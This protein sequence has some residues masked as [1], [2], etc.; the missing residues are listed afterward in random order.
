VPNSY[1]VGV[2]ATYAY[3]DLGRRS[4]L[5]RGDGSVLSYGY[6][7]VS[8]LT[9]LGDNLAGTAYD[10]TL[11]FGYNPASQ[12]ASNTR[13][14][15]AYAWT[16]HYNLNRGYVA[17]GLNQYSATGSITPTYDSKGNLTSAG[18][19]TY[20]YTSENLL[21]SLTNSAP[22]AIQAWSTYSYD[23]LMRLAVIDSSNNSF[24]ASLAYDGQDFIL[25][26]LS[27]GR[28]RRYVR[29]P[30][31]DEPLV[32]YL[33]TPAGTSRL[34]YQ[35]DERG[36]IVR[37]S[38]DAGTPGQIGKYDEYGIGG[39]GRIRYAGQYWLGDGNLIYSRA[40]IYDARLGRFLQPDPIGYGDGMNMYA[41]VGG[42][43][44]NRTDPSGLG[45]ATVKIGGSSTGEGMEAEITRA[46]YEELCWGEG[47]GWGP[48]RY[49]DGI[50]GGGGS[51]QS[52]LKCKL[53][54]G[55]IDVSFD[56]TTLNIRAN[57]TL[58]GPGADASSAYIAG[59]GTA[60]TQN[61]GHINSIANISA[62]PDGVIAEISSG[63]IPPGG[64]RS[65]LGGNHM[66]LGNLGAMSARQIAYATQHVAPH[67]F[68][69]SLKIDNM[70]PVGK[71]KGAIMANSANNVS[72]TDLEA[73]VE[74]CRG[75][76]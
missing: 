10:Q 72:A 63:I 2:L 25:E 8:R 21:T 33:V 19:K 16:G 34:W 23:P 31:I 73:V 11:G 13:S 27:G 45:C 66:W 52:E 36:S 60:W 51:T 55:K 69:H 32:A 39:S 1:G 37:H 65:T 42:D 68:G 44:V 18:A 59:I 43:P 64:P 53:G 20:A 61:Y 50:A 46:A 12:I 35:A 24:D 15:D 74:A 29:G 71:W 4:S 75:A 47:G 7:A 76:Q 5:T 6:D 17:N 3:D 70:T 9:S 14:N 54:N 22:G 56:G 57:I 62:G 30:G 49:F 58:T 40:R 28:T 48:T 38:N 26:G 67:E 41:Y